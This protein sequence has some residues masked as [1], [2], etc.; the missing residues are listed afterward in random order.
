MATLKEILQNDIDELTKILRK[1]FRPLSPAIDISADPK[2]ALTVL[3]NL[4]E[5]VNLQ[6]DLLNPN[7][8]EAK[9]R[10][11]KWWA[12]CLETAS[13][14]QSHNVKYPDIRATGLIRS[15]PIGELPPFALS[16]SNVPPIDWSYSK[17]SN[18]VN[19]AAFLT[20]EFIWNDQQT[21]LTV[22]LKDVKHPIWLILIE[23]G[24]TKKKQKQIANSLS[25]IPNQTIE[26]ELRYNYLKHVIFPD[27]ANSYVTLSPVPS[28][29]LQSHVYQALENEYKLTARTWFDRATNMGCLAMTCAGAF[30]TIKSIPNIKGSRH[31]YLKGVPYWLTKSVFKS[32]S[33]YAKSEQWILTKNDFKQR[34]N[35][36][37]DDI[38]PALALWINQVDSNQKSATQLAEELNFELASSQYTARLS[39]DYKLTKLF[40]HIFNQIIID[41]SSLPL[42][43]NNSS[44][45]KFL[46]LPCLKIR[47]ASALNTPYS[48][49]LPS[50][51]A[52][53]GFVHALERKLLEI[54]AEYSV[55]SF[56]IC[57]HSISLNKRGLTRES[58]LKS[59]KQVSPPATQDEWLCD[60]EVSVLIQCQS[61]LNL[62]S[63]TLFKIM[64]K[65]LARGSIK[66]PIDKIQTLQSYSS[67][68]SAIKG[69]EQTGGKWLS[70]HE[71]KKLENVND[72]IEELKKDRRLFLNTIGY[73]LLEVPKEKQLALKG[74]NHAF[75]E[76]ILALIRAVSVSEKS[77]LDDIFWQYKYEK[78]GPRLLTRSLHETANT[79]IVSS[80]N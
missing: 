23:L 44:P 46:L 53:Y 56:A 2:T 65:T 40:T 50:L 34:I 47:A 74:Y 21:C 20:S 41:R 60:I 22:L 77:N 5:K 75:A 9:L 59:N 73:H 19:H 11:D 26:A 43:L 51:M 38:K 25:K 24:C 80:I 78:S 37:I 18:N 33:L 32:L 10:D 7:T 8:C 64:P 63:T 16:S 57:I 45:G 79:P 17:N 35:L 6:K 14:R 54:N 55:D 49:G 30:K 31:N 72:I 71:K 61:A 36:V 3:I 29:S 4:T 70:L 76:N 66:I 27:D 12:D 58:I 62:S 28:Q 68:T 39:Y 69:I 67:A 13:N 1:A 15:T 48:L 42:T 52:F